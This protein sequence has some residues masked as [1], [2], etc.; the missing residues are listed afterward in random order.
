MKLEVLQ[1]SS[2]P[3]SWSLPV[4]ASLVMRGSF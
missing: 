2:E 1:R 3:S 4:L